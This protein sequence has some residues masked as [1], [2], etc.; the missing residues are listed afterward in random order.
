MT[1]AEAFDQ[2]APIAWLTMQAAFW[3]ILLVATTLIPPAVMAWL[4]IRVLGWQRGLLFIGLAV[5][6]GIRL[7]ALIY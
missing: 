1:A 4:P 5:A 2:L 6:G 3:F 7:H